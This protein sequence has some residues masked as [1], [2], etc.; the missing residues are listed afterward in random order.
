[1][2]WSEIK[3]N[4]KCKPCITVRTIFKLLYKNYIV[5]AS[6]SFKRDYRSYSVINATSCELD[7]NHNPVDLLG[8]EGF[9]S[10][11]EIREMASKNFKKGYR[12]DKEFIYKNWA[13]HC[14]DLLF[15]NKEK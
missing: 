14:R 4:K 6:K 7:Y 13:S 5:E 15:S 3:P 2:W 8:K 9:Q 1:M 11:K 12:S 10:I